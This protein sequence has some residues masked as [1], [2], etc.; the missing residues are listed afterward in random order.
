[1]YVWRQS[2][3]PPRWVPLI[4]FAT[5]RLLEGDTHW[6]VGVNEKQVR[7][8]RGEG[9]GEGEERRE[10][11]GREGRKGEGGEEERGELMLINIRS[12]AWCAK[13]TSPQQSSHVPCS[14]QSTCKSPSSH[15]VMLKP[16]SKKKSIF[17]TLSP[18]TSIPPLP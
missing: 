17:P 6:V 16:Q 11:R 14:V 15:V 7:P 3:A 18:S 4:D 1:M 8:G 5:L 13:E 10:E 12:C 9:E 2:S